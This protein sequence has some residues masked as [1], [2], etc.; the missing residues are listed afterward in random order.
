[1]DMIIH[2][3]LYKYATICIV[4]TYSMFDFEIGKL[5]EQ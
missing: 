1:M 2:R 5:L 3:D 4:S